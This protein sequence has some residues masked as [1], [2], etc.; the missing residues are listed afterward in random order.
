L[1]LKKVKLDSKA[2]SVKIETNLI[3]VAVVW[4]EQGLLGCSGKNL[5]KLDGKT[6]C[7]NLEKDKSQPIKCISFNSAKSQPDVL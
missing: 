3:D 2:K 5:G 6:K 4:S 7:I 1:T